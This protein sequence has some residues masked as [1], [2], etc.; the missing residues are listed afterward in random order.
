MSQPYTT[1]AKLVIRVKMKKNIKIAIAAS[2]LV[3]LI[4][5]YSTNSV[6]QDVEKVM[7]GQVAYEDTRGTPIDSYNRGS[8]GVNS[9]HPINVEVNIMRLFVLHN[10]ADGY[11]WIMYTNEGLDPNTNS[12]YGSYKVTSRWKIHKENGKWVIVDIKEGP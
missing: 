10:F 4:M 8:G 7:R 11:M 3:Y 12:R 2:L 6:V 5:F 1:I 9:K